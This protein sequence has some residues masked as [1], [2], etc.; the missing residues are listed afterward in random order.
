[1]IYGITGLVEDDRLTHIFSSTGHI[2]LHHKIH[3]NHFHIFDFAILD[4]DARQVNAWHQNM[5]STFKI[6]IVSNIIDSFIN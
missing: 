3:I 2:H 6:N 5:E 1:M 4:D